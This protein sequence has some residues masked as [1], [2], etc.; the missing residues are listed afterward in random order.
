MELSSEQVA[1]R[2]PIW[3][4]MS[5]LFLDNEDLPYEWA[6]RVCA[7]SHFTVK[8][9]EEI[10]FK[11]VYPVLAP[12]LMPTGMVWTGF[13]QEWLQQRILEG[14]RPIAYMFRSPGRLRRWLTPQ[15]RRLR[16]EILKHRDTGVKHAP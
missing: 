16:N 10:F 11:E 3:E 2:Q 4:A 13:D 6:G 8:E 1:V 15:W 5:E 12:N 14:S 9:L 7:N